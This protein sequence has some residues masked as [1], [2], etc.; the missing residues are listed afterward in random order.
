MGT[1]PFVTT[2]LKGHFVVF[3]TVAFD[4]LGD[5]PAVLSNWPRRV[6]FPCRGQ[7]QRNSCCE[8]TTKRPLKCVA[9]KGTIQLYN[10][11]LFFIRSVK[12]FSKSLFVHN[13]YSSGY[14][15][16]LGKVNPLPPLLTRNPLPHFI[17]SPTTGLTK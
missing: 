3:F 15:S 11:Q 12:I 2:L 17:P 9:T 5:C 10:T 7:K 6:R 16:P 13:K 14:P 1:V 8:N 4:R